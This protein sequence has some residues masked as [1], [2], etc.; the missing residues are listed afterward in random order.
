MFT[1]IKTFIFL[2]ISLVIGFSSC[3]S[4]TQTEKQD[5]FSSTTSTI[6]IIQFHS[7]HRCVTCVKIEEL[8]RTT[9]TNNSLDIPFTLV[10]VEDP[11]NAAVAE[12]FEAFGTAL[13]LYNPSSGFKKNLT[14]FAFMKSG[15][16]KK[17][18]QELKKQIEEFIKS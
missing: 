8:T 18:E 9:L 14:E 1:K 11:A 15:D 17:F 4:Q 13:F 3:T 2:S 12:E 5:A 10:N 7:E 16:E 6:E